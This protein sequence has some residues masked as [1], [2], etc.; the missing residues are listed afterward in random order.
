MIKENVFVKL[1]SLQKMMEVVLDVVKIAKNVPR[2]KD[3]LSVRMIT[4][5]QVNQVFVNVRLVCMKMEQNVRIVMIPVK[6]A[7]MEVPVKHA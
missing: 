5:Y 4:E 2:M 7:I 6:L 1:D 3:V